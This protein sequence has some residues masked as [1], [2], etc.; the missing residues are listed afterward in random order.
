MEQGVQIHYLSHHAVIRHDKEMTRLQ[1]VYDAPAKST[2][3]L[4]NDG[5]H[6][7]LKFDQ[8]IFDLLLRFRVHR[9]AITADIKKAS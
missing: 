1:T 7:G 6:A 2:G 3:L 9:V 8:R 4:L 5:L